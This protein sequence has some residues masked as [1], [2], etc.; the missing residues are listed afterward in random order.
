MINNLT[1]EKLEEIKELD[2]YTKYLLDY[3]H[4]DASFS[5][6]MGLAAMYGRGHKSMSVDSYD[7]K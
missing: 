2:D 6:I 3:M 7:K 5:V 1:N 4:V